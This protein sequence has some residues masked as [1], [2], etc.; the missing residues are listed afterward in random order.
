M[1]DQPELPRGLGWYAYRAYL[2]GWL[3]AS[4]RHPVGRNVYETDWDL[5]V[6]LDACRVDA[7]R[8][9]APEYDFVDGVESVRSVASTSDEWMAQTFTPE[10]AAAIR[11]THYVTA[12]AFAKQVV[13]EREMPGDDRLTSW[14]VVGPGAFHRIDH[15]W[16]QKPETRFPHV[17]ADTLTD[18][19][20]AAGRESDAGRL[21]VHYLQ[22]HDPYVANALAEDREM[23]PHEADPFGALRDGTATLDTVWA[24]YLDNLRYVLDSVARLL[25]NVDAE[26]AVLTADHGEAFGEWGLYRHLCGNLHPAVKRVPWVETTAEDTGDSEPTVERPDRPSADVEEQLRDLGYRL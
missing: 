19:A 16:E 26:R 8:A 6:V 14:D 18:R 3:A 11:D 1:G 9:V 17:L 4:S 20:I 22:P 23:A 12:N 21:V 10:H 5:L 25:A 24:S 7:L 2:K 13:E 15:V